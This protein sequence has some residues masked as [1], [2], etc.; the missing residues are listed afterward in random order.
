M[1][2]PAARS[3][4]MTANSCSTSPR[5]RLEVG[6]SRISTRD[7]EHHGAADRDQLLDGDRVAGQQR[8]GVDLHAEAS[9]GAR[10]PARCAAFQSMPAAAVRLVAE[11]DVLA[12]GQVRAEVDLLV[13]RRDAGGLGVGGACGTRLG[14][15]ATV[16]VA[17]VDGVHAGQRLDEGRLAGAVLAHERVDLARAQ[18]EVDVVEGQHPREADGDAPHLDDRG[19]WRACRVIAHVSHLSGVG[20]TPTG[21]PED[22]PPGACSLVVQGSTDCLSTG[23]SR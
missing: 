14:A 1:A 15:P 4:R 18:A 16:I 11:H 9:P 13:H 10:R 7:V 3:S 6:S 22:R 5:S 2:T 19:S 23:V 20:G 8:V 17:G 21:G 12:D